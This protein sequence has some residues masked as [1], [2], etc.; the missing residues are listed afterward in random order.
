MRVSLPEGYRC[1]HDCCQA[2]PGTTDP[3]ERLQ[4]DHKM[5]RQSDQ[6][7]P[8]IGMGNAFRNV[9]DTIIHDYRVMTPDH[10]RIEQFFIEQEVL[11]IP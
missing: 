8:A 1:R 11:P 6:E 7:C 3:P 9:P 5:P 2:L 10:I 4:F